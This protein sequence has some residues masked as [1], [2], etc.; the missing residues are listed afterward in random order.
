MKIRIRKIPFAN[1]SFA[2][3]FPA[4]CERLQKKLVIKVPKIEIKNKK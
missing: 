1:G 3:A 4:Y 2:Y